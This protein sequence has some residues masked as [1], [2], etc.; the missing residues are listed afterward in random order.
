LTSVFLPIPDRIESPTAVVIPRLYSNLG[1]DLGPAATHTPAITAD[2]LALAG[3]RGPSAGCCAYLHRLPRSSRQRRV[4]TGWLVFTNRAA[5]PDASSEGRL[6][7]SLRLHAC[8]VSIA[9]PSSP[10]SPG[11]S[12]TTTPRVLI[13]VPPSRTWRVQ[14]RR[15]SDQPIWRMSMPSMSPS[16]RLPPFEHWAAAALPLRAVASQPLVPAASYQRAFSGMYVAGDS[17][18]ATPTR[19]LQLRRPIGP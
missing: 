14:C 8:A 16:M 11:T 12:P 15:R 17:H 7:A 3:C 1:V 18:A 9:S 10:S 13:C 19:A 6:G 4:R 2:A 5:T